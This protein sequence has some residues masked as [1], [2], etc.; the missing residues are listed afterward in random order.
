MVTRDDLAEKER[1]KLVDEAKEIKENLEHL[2]EA[3]KEEVDVD[4]EE[5][6]PDLIERE[7]NVALA[8]QLE[9]KLE[10]VQAALRAID[11]GRYG[12]CERCGKE[13]DPERLEVK[14]DA[15]L[16]LQCQVEVEKLIKRGLMPTPPPDIQ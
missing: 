2:R 13:I 1:Q 4:A 8:S 16:C 10:G 14:P 15:T 6:D 3:M 5:G 12:L 11:K 9:R 7:K